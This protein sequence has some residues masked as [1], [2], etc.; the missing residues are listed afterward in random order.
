MAKKTAKAGACSSHTIGVK[1]NCL[2]HARRDGKLPSNVV[3]ERTQDNIT[4]F[5]SDV[6]RNRRSIMPLSRQAEKLYTEKTGQKVQ[7]SFAPFRESVL[8]INSK[9][10]PDQLME[11]KERCEALTGWTALGIW[12]HKDEGH[13]HS[14]Y[15]EGDTGFTVHEHAHVLW[16]CQDHV[17]GK[18]IRC[19]RDRLSMMQDI[20]S[21]VTGMERG[22]K[23]ADTGIGYRKAAEERQAKMEARIE[24]LEKVVQEKDGQIK[25]Q[26]LR[27]SQ[28]EQIIV[29]QDDRLSEAI[30]KRD[31]AM[32]EVSEIRKQMLRWANSAAVWAGELM[33]RIKQGIR[34]QA[35]EVDM[36]SQIATGISKLPEPMQPMAEQRWQVVRDNVPEELTYD[37]IM[38]LVQ[39]AAVHTPAGTWRIVRGFDG[40]FSLS[41]PR[42][43]ESGGSKANQ[44][45]MD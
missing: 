13:A 21:E 32:A 25:D 22:N 2:Q 23:A 3:P 30:S 35:A 14:K 41:R 44:W 16:D 1:A 17:T 38:R 39:G 36:T 5:E 11:F 10:T 4:V 42:S 12:M 31:K 28:N 18:A 15:I 7:K 45:V 24:M 8:H 27:I 6:I 34:V 37:Q 29:Q 33:E 26:E 40:S 43:A 19:T 20:L 9:V